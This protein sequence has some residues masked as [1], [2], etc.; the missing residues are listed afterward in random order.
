METTHQKEI[1]MGDYVA[2]RG[3]AKIKPELVEIFRKHLFKEFSWKELYK[4]LPFEFKSNEILRDLMH[5]AN[6]SADTLLT[7]NGCTTSF[8]GEVESFVSKLALSED[9]QLDIICGQKH[10]EWHNQYLFVALLPSI[11]ESWVMDVDAHQ[12]MMECS[13]AYG[14]M[15]GFTGTEEE[16]EPTEDERLLEHGIR[17]FV[18]G[19]ESIGNTF[20]AKF[21][22][23]RYSKTSSFMHSE[24]GEIVTLITRELY[25]LAGCRQI[26]KLYSSLV[27]NDKFK[28]A[29]YRQLFE[30]YGGRLKQNAGVAFMIAPDLL[31]LPACIESFC[32]ITG[33]ISV[34]LAGI[35]KAKEFAIDDYKGIALVIHKHITT[36]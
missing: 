2:M 25:H 9:G 30:A 22:V 13:I 18:N 36:N 8:Q 23:G 32:F 27:A 20:I 15:F 16:P 14:G 24:I 6:D 31:R 7:S 5:P 17:R 11:A 12:L 34:A 10:T 4:D 1:K 21:I 19:V 35:P 3:T 26:F 28:F 33:K 29:L